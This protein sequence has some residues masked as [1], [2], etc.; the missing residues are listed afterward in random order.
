MSHYRGE[1]IECAYRG[2]EKKYNGKRINKD[3]GRNQH[4]KVCIVKEAWNRLSSIFSGQRY[5]FATL[6]YFFWYF[7]SIFV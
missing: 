3:T 2:D 6:N 7:C 5:R 1:K 4:I